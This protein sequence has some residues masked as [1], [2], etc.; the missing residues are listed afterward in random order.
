[1]P[2]SLKGSEELSLLARMPIFKSFENLP[3]MI[4]QESAEQY[5]SSDAARSWNRILTYFAFVMTHHCAAMVGNDRQERRVVEVSGSNPAWKL[6][7]PDTVMSLIAIPLV[8]KFPSQFSTSL[9]SHELT[10]LFGQRHDCITF[11]ESEGAL[12]GFCSVL[13]PQC[14]Q[15]VPIYYE[16]PKPATHFIL[17]A[18]DNWPKSL[19]ELRI[20][21]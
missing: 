14:S 4:S 15:C 16:Q 2:S 5:V 13:S 17:F 20:A 21:T 1:M 6:F 18:G 10:I 9:T 3:L 7:V 19:V 12:L 8:P 11:S